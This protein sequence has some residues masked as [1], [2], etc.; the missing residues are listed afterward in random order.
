M[1][2]FDPQRGR[3]RRALARDKFTHFAHKTRDGIDAAA[4][5]W[6]NRA[7]G[8]VAV[9]RRR[10]RSEPHDEPGNIPALQGGNED[11]T[12]SPQW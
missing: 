10:F 11:T 6:S 5:D 3:R 7:A 1:Y 2:V 9:A 8:T 4:R 12:A